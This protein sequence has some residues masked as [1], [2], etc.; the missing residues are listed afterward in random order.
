MENQYI[1]QINGINPLV[2]G[3]EQQQLESF[4]SDSIQLPDNTIN[5]S[6]S[7]SYPTSL[8][9]DEFDVDLDVN[10]Y[11]EDK[12]AN[13]SI[14]E[15]STDN[16]QLSTVSDD[17]DPLIGDMPTLLTGVMLDSN[18]YN[19]KEQLETFASDEEFFDK[20][21]LAFENDFST[22]EAKTLI[23]DLASGEAIPE[24]EIIPAA[25]LNNANGAF[26]EGTIYLSEKFLT[27][28]AA[29]PGAVESVLLE[30]IGHYVDQELGGSDSMGDEGDIF[31][32]V[33]RGETITGDEL[34][35][36]KAE[37]DS[38][39]ISLNGKEIYV[40]LN[41]SRTEYTIKSGD[42]LWQIAQQQLGD[43]NRWVEIEKENGTTFTQQEA[44]SLQIGQ[45]VYLPGTSPVLPVGGSS[46]VSTGGGS[47]YDV[48]QIINSPAVGTDIRQYA[49][50]SVPVILSEAQRSG[51]T[52]AG[53]IAYI[54]ATAELESQLGLYMEEIASGEQYEGLPQY[55]NTQPGDGVRF[56][57]R[58]YV[59]ITGRRNYTDWSQ[60]LGI[61]LVS[62]P[63]LAEQPDIAAK[64][65][66][67]GMRDGTFTGKELSDYINGG[68]RDFVNARRIVNGLDKAQQIATDAQRY[69]QAL[70]S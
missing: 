5:S 35:A 51:V 3:L 48:N 38:A 23:Q 16:V 40:E 7:L 11:F 43:G 22:N 62:N 36:I 30:E 10:P 29:N 57:G 68:N 19:V 21:K 47:S 14:S 49:E 2:T 1:S 25:Q 70:T 42:N 27:E 61:D 59:Q 12:F 33:V 66:V 20:M 50:V 58:G 9:I 56:K 60:R 37:D 46:P 63:E 44:Q 26:G 45:V 52:D 53:Q 15:T 55:G 24:I 67:Q 65:L 28:N 32:K 69:Y 18:I 34:A 6:G 31:S 54:L 13:L 41:E 39:T 17:F 64:I 8:E 4:T